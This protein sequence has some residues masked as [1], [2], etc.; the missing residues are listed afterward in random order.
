MYSLEN[1]AQPEV[2][3]D[4]FSGIWWAAST[5]LTVGYGDIYP[6]TIA[7]K[8]LGIVITFLGAGM[9]AIPTGIISAGFVDQYSNI[10]KRTEFGYE[11]DMN[12]IKIRIGANDQWLGKRIAELDLPENVIIAI[13][14]R[15]EEIIIPRGDIVLQEKDSIVLGAAPFEEHEKINLKE[16]V[17]KEQNPWNGLRIRDLDI[18][19]H[20]VIVLVKRRKKALIPNGNMILREGDRVFLYTHQHLLDVSEIEI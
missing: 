7:G 14:K 19:R 2:F 12:F 11:A 18:S 17:L 9:V 15:K 10:K 4:A 3:T 13:L 8:I 6:V 5:L 16:I 1:E 20:T